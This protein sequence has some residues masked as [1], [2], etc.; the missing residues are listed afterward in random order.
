M[1]T[2]VAWNQAVAPVASF[3]NIQGAKDQHV[4]VVDDRVFVP[5]KLNKIVFCAASGEAVHRARLES[6]SLRRLAY[7]MISPLN[8]LAVTAEHGQPPMMYQGESPLALDPAEGLEAKVYMGAPD[9][10]FNTILLGL[11]DSPIVPVKGEIWT[12]RATATITAEEGVWVNSEIT[13]DQT[14]PVGRYQIVGCECWSLTGHA[15]RLVPIG[16]LNRP[17]GIV[18]REHQLIDPPW[19]RKGGL[20]VWCEF[21][22]VTPPSVDLLASSA[23]AQ[24]PVLHLDL[25]KIA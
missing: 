4:K 17:G 25:I 1:L 5:E 11:S 3:E 10:T 21:D 22:S 7:L 8:T 15:F 20:G 16:Q 19:Q 23:V 14:L 24:F 18:I 12:V 13:F 2:V 6:P 9:A